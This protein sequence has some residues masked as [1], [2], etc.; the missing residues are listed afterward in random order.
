MYLSLFTFNASSFLNSIYYKDK[1]HP[2]VICPQEKS[3]SRNTKSTENI[4]KQPF[5]KPEKVF[6]DLNINEVRSPGIKCKPWS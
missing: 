3:K 6:R 1:G 2:N 5:T 4:V